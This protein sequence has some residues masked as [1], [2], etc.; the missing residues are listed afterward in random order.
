MPPPPTTFQKALC[1]SSH[2][3][4][5]NIVYFL[6]LCF[7]TASWLPQSSLTHFWT[8]H[9]EDHTSNTPNNVRPRFVHF[10]SYFLRRTTTTPAVK[11]GWRSGPH[12]HRWW[13][14]PSVNIFLY[15]D[16]Q[17]PTA[18]GAI[19]AMSANLGDLLST[20]L[21]YQKPKLFSNSH[22]WWILEHIGSHFGFKKI[23]S[24]GVLLLF[25]DE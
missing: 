1:C 11:R 14:C 22:T 13:L 20:H 3:C 19:S 15:P 2:F 10:A 6:G 7:Q 12:V 17:I 25:S 4:P 18:A 23:P 5:L 8:L 16:L 9:T 21:A 24:L